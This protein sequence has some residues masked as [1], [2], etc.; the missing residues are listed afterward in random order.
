MTSLA[1][2][3]DTQGFHHR[4]D[5][6]ACGS[7]RLPLILPLGTTPL[8]NA[9]LRSP[10]E[11]PSER[12]YPLDVYF[13]ENC[14]LIQL[15]DVVDPTILFSH[16]VYVSGTSDT[17]RA[18]SAQ[19]AKTVVDLLRLGANNLVFEIASNDG[20]LLKCFQEYDVRTLG[21]EPA[22]NVAA[23]AN[24]SGVPTVNRFFDEIAAIDLVREYGIGAAVIANNVLAHV[25]EPVGFLRGCAS[26]ISDSGRIIVEAPYGR[27]FLEKLEY[28]TVYHEH[29]SYF[30][31]TALLTIFANAGLSIVRVDHTPVHGGSIRVY[32]VHRT[33]TPQH[34]LEVL[35]VAD[36]EAALG[37]KAVETYRG[38][39]DAVDDNRTELLALLHRLQAE[40]KTIAAYGAPAKGNTLLNYAGIG[41]SLVE[42]TVDKNQLKVG[43]YTPGMHLPVLPVE[44]LLERQPDYVLILAWNFTEEIMSQQQEYK[45]RGGRFI[46][47]IP[48][49]RII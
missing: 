13:C 26:L 44:T 41:P 5:C 2:A 28:D 29:L 39:A 37:Y 27:H 38:F 16:Y 31:V 33:L 24:A 36:E 18:H 42:Y 1:A 19:Y 12:S 6:R 3:T 22:S 45:Q 35:A 21:I 17:I 34:S 43:S 30:S 46:I 7:D 40:G 4:K 8:A 10:S 23:I 25:D 15:L 9:F 11:F 14:S 47:P 48:T 49:P 20:T 32:A